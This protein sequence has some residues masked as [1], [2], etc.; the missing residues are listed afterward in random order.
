MSKDEQ[1]SSD[2]IN[3]AMNLTSFE[4]SFITENVG[5]ISTNVCFRAMYIKNWTN[6]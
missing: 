2:Y 5:G 6:P 4:K 1:N 3:F